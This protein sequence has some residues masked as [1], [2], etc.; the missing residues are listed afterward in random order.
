MGKTEEMR[1]CIILCL[2]VTGLVYCKKDKTP[3]QLTVDKTELSLHGLTNR[4]ASIELTTEAAWQI[5][6][7]NLPDWLQIEPTS[8]TGNAAIR[9]INKVEN[10]EASAETTITIT[11]SGHQPATIKISRKPYYAGPVLKAIGGSSNE[12][13]YKAVA[14]RD[15]GY[16]AVGYTES[17]DDDFTGVVNAGRSDGLVIKY[18]AN[19]T[20]QWKKTYGG[21]DVDVLNGVITTEDG[22]YLVVGSSLSWEG[23]FQSNKGQFD[24][25]IMKLDA[26]GNKSW[27]KLYGS[28]EDDACYAA[29]PVSG[30]YIIAGSNSA[31]N[32]DVSKNSGYSDAWVLMLNN[33]GEKQW[34][35][36]YGG[37]SDYEGVYAAIPTPDGNF[38]LAGYYG[39]TDGPA[40]EGGWGTLDAWLMKC[41]KDGNM[42]WSK[43]FGGSSADVFHDVCV[44]EKGELIA[45]GSTK[46]NDGQIP[47]RRGNEDALLVKTSGAGELQWLRLAAGS[48]DEVWKA[49]LYSPDKGIMTAGYTSSSDLS[50][51]N[52]GS[53][54]ALLCWYDH[55][56]ESPK[57]K[58]VG[59]DDTDAAFFLTKTNNFFV[60]G[61]SYESDDGDFPPNYGNTDCWS[62]QFK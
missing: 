24:C 56:G 2:M 22:G 46:S 14:T 7:S 47:E 35:R 53:A 16:I 27:N 28:S 45:V 11:A 36:S 26:T 42:I 29:L 60:W 12:V 62:I 18:A 20:E 6:T 13:L 61:G 32:G 30:G 37:S 4:E 39:S 58:S 1:T 50:E 40:A 10:N 59:G 33:A 51:E 43:R 3:P 44:T 9:F 23:E 48:M 52:K 57:Y 34:E 38:V 31:G 55:N 25:W 41:N 15:G 54:D 21:N 49:V 17:D 19:G 8:G 5:S